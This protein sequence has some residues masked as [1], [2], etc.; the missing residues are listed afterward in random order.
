MLKKAANRTGSTALST[1][2]GSN[3]V[4]GQRDIVEIHGN[5]EDAT[6]TINAKISVSVISINASFKNDT[7][8]SLPIRKFQ[9][10]FP[11]AAGWSSPAG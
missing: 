8:K 9:D 3:Q 4:Y 2:S 11:P 6:F 7:S 1:I 5:Y 10:Y